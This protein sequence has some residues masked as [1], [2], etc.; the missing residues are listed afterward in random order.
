MIKGIINLGVT[1]LVIAL[2][3]VSCKKDKTKIETCT[4]CNFTCVDENEVDV[5]INNCLPNWECSFQVFD[6]STIDIE[7]YKG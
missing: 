1:F 3:V 6:N 2:T 4:D 5:I 7:E